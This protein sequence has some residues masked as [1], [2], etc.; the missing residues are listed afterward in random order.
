MRVEFVHFHFKI[1]PHLHLWSAFHW[2]DG[3]AD[4]EAAENQR[5][6]NA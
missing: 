4:K 3:V 5:L 2:T 6:L 1:N